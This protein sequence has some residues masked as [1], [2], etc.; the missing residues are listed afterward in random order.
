MVLGALGRQVVALR[1]T[2]FEDLP[3]GLRG[4][5]YRNGPAKLKA[6]WRRRGRPSGLVGC[7]C[8]VLSASLSSLYLLC[9]HRL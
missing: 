5:Y 4:T 8:L 6:D 9:G 7:K 2:F 1:K 3:V